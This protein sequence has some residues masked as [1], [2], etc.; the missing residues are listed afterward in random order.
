MMPNLCCVIVYKLSTLSHPFEELGLNKEVN[1]KLNLILNYSL[2]KI[3][4]NVS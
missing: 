3:D 4:P 2:L 1:F